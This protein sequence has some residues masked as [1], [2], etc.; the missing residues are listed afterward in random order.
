MKRR[1][2]SGLLLSAIPPWISKDARGL[3]VS[4][5][6]I[7]DETTARGDLTSEHSEREGEAP[8]GYAGGGGDVSPYQ[9]DG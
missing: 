1:N 4:G 2:S 7:T 9:I 6:S 5:M 3:I 8:S